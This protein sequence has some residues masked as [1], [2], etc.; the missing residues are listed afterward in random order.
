MAWLPFTLGPQ[1]YSTE[2]FMAFPPYLPGQADTV[3]VAIVQYYVAR[4]GGLPGYASPRANICS[5]I[6]SSLL[7]ILLYY[8]RLAGHRPWC[9]KVYH[10]RA[11]KLISQH[12]FV[13]ECGLQL[14][15]T[16]LLQHNC[17]IAASR[18]AWLISAVTWD[19][20]MYRWAAK[21]RTFWWYVFQNIAVRYVLAV[22]EVGI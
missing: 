7:R 17:L 18:A 8:R 3:V 12:Y 4:N 20:E 19:L 11:S 10:F 6:I 2:L 5:K 15:E 21:V 13:G 1:S 14:R 22:A 9:S 16:P